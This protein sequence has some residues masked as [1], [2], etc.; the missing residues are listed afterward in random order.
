[1]NHIWRWLRAPFAWRRD[2]IA[3][4]YSYE[5]NAI[6][7][8]RRVQ[9]CVCGGYS[10][11]DL[12][13]V[14]RRDKMEVTPPFAVRPAPPPMRIIKS[15]GWLTKTSTGPQVRDKIGGDAWQ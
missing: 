7:G 13:W 12:D 11:I 5:E 15:G 6:T 14:L 9:R 3:G 4:F 10:P 1:M 8:E 2:H